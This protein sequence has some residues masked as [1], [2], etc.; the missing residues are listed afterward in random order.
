MNKMFTKGWSV[1]YMLQNRIETLFH[2]Y[3]TLGKS[4]GD[5]GK[6]TGSAVN[7]NQGLRFIS[8]NMGFWRKVDTNI[9]MKDVR[10]NDHSPPGAGSGLPWCSFSR[11]ARCLLGAVLGFFFPL[12]KVQ[13]ANLKRIEGEAEMVVE[14]VETVAEV[15]EK[16]ATAAEKVS[17]EVAEKLPDDSML[18]IAAMEVEH[19]SEITAH[20]AH[21]TTHFI[22]QV[23]EIKHEL[24]DLVSKLEKQG[25]QKIDS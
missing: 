18:K 11:W 3:K 23:E 24:D 12:W 5:M 13:C 21:A 14:G 9:A 15:V 16:V 10:E 7:N 2:P 8:N 17:A 22:H 19:V 20:D 1:S 4:S 25:P 6:L